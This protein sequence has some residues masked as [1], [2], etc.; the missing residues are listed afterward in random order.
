MA[1]P[2]SGLQEI[3]LQYGLLILISSTARLQ[4]SPNRQAPEPSRLRY[5]KV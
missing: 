2:A 4:P 1:N 3:R 5:P